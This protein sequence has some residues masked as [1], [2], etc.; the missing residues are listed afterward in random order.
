MLRKHL[1]HAGQSL[2]FACQLCEGRSFASKQDLV[3]HVGTNHPATLSEEALIDNSSGNVCRVRLQLETLDQVMNVTIEPW[4]WVLPSNRFT[5]GEA[6]RFN[7]L[8]EVREI[9]LALEAE[10]GFKE[11]ANR[12]VK[13]Y[14][15]RVHLAAFQSGEALIRCHSIPI[16]VSV[17]YD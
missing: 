3:K 11:A 7:Q 6:M 2:P 12:I 13:G 17:M 4:F 16:Q 10:P 5:N 15:S 14:F 9:L 1:R 8:R